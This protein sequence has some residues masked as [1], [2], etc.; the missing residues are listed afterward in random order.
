MIRKHNIFKVL[1]LLVNMADQNSVKPLRWRNI[2]F[3]FRF[4]TQF[5]EVVSSPI[6]PKSEIVIRTH[7]R[8]TIQIK[9]RAYLSG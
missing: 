5:R 7:T 6:I 9:L 1:K 3:N 2:K 8:R 4:T